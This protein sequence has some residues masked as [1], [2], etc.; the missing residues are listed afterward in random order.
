[1]STVQVD[2]TLVGV[3]AARLPWTMDGGPI[4]AA[5]A[6][7][8]GDDVPGEK[9]AQPDDPVALR[10]QLRAVAPTL[11]ELTDRVRCAFDEDQACAVVIPEMGLAEFDD[12]HRR[13][14]MYAFAAL[15][16]DPLAITR[17]K[18]WYGTCGTEAT[19]MGCGPVTPPPA[20]PPATTPTPGI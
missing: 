2:Q 3:D 15:L 12:D 11:A 19:K 4:R 13:K 16:G 18:R 17:A 6:E 9:L 5:L 8:C 1:M 14:G 10:A 20:E 7:H